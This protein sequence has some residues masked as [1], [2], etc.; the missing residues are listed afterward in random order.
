LLSWL[1]DSIA[2]VVQGLV[3]FVAD[4]VDLASGES[5][6]PNHTHSSAT[7]ASSS[8]ASEKAFTADC[9]P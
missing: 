2:S 3:D 5:L 7:R 6:S 9:D 8:G 4:T 1:A